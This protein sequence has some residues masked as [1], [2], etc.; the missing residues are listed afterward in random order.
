MNGDGFSD[1][2][3]GADQYD[4]GQVNEGRAFVYL[5]SAGAFGPGAGG[6]QATKWVGSVDVPARFWV[7]SSL[8]ASDLPTIVFA[9]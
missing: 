4:N 2:I 1:V 5:G 7:T 9:G 8:A 3:V 6:G